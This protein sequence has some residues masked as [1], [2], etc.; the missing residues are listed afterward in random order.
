MFRASILA[1]MVMT[2][3]VTDPTDIIPFRV[4]AQARIANLASGNTPLARGNGLCKPCNAPIYMAR[5]HGTRTTTPFR[6]GLG[7]LLDRVPTEVSARIQFR[8]VTTHDA[9]NRLDLRLRLGFDLGFGDGRIALARSTLRLRPSLKKF[10]YGV[11]HF[12]RPMISK[13]G[14]EVAP[15]V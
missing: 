6:S 12:F 3:I 8:A 15:L 5:T 13:G 9:T 7:V 2:A 1:L 4:T 14:P 10:V 11:S